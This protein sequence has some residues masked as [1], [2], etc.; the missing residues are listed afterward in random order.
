MDSCNIFSNNINYII[1]NKK[2]IK[3][4][5]IYHYPCEFNSKNKIMENK[6]N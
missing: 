5:I 6:S 2:E 1:N 4:A 3:V